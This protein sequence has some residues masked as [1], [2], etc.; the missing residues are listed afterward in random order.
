MFQRDIE[1]LEDTR[2][3][4]NVLPL[5]AGALSGTSLPIDRQYVAELLAFPRVQENSMDAV[6]D[7]D[8]ILEFLGGLSILFLHL[9]RWGEEIVLWSSP[10]F[11]LEIDDAFT[12]AQVL[13]LRKKSRC[14]SYYEENSGSIELL[15]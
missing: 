3:R 11:T 12:T 5:G 1:R 4:V 10:A 2:K 15:G 9:S 13:C 7:R 6:S 8:V 14:R